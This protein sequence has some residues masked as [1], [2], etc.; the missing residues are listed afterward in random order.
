MTW[1]DKQPRI[2]LEHKNSKLSSNL[3]ET[4]HVRDWCITITLSVLFSQI[5]KLKYNW[6]LKEI[7]TLCMTWLKDRSRSTSTLKGKKFSYFTFHGVNIVI[8]GD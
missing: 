3:S 4:L 8:N 2:L 5:N 6:I 7:F 1:H